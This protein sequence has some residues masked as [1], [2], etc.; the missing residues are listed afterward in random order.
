M[1]RTKFNEETVKNLLTYYE[2]GIPLK[3]ASELAGV[4]RRTVY[5]WKTKGE[6]AKSG[7]YKKFVDDLN[8]A[9]AKFVAYHHNK[10]N[11][12]SDPRVSQYLLQVTDPE[13]YVIEKRF[14]T[15]NSSEIRVEEVKT[16]KERDKENEDYFRQLEKDMENE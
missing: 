8:K 5:D 1:V 12:S 3:Y 14:K 15:D 7:K 6:N 16:L 2:N 9:R 4:S 13:T 10:L 11:E